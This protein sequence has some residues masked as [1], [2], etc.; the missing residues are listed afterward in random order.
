MGCNGTSDKASS[1]CEHHFSLM[2]NAMADL[3]YRLDFV[4][5]LGLSF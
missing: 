2:S 3:I 1:E 4:R 5:T